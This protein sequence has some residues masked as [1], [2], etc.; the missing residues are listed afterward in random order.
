MKVCPIQDLCLYF[1]T[2]DNKPKNHDV[3][4]KFPCTKFLD[5]SCEESIRIQLYL[6]ETLACDIGKINRIKKSLKKQ[7]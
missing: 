3:R 1:E 4:N 6:G 2:G 7:R 5:M